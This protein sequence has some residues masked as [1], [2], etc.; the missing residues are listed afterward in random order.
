M[1]LLP[2]FIE[3]GSYLGD[4]EQKISWQFFLRHGV[5]DDIAEGRTPPAPCV[6]TDHVG[7]VGDEWSI[8]GV[9]LA[10]LDRRTSLYTTGVDTRVYSVLG[11]ELARL[12]SIQ[13]KSITSVDAQV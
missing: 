3:I 9:E 2:I 10:G 4:K 5:L 11:V 7:R 6:V 1:T 8:V 13:D 12:V